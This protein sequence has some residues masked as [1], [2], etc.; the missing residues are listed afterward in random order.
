M[1]S[2]SLSVYNAAVIPVLL[3]VEIYACPEN[4]QNNADLYNV[5]T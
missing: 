5:E 1:A 2:Y 4:T 3:S